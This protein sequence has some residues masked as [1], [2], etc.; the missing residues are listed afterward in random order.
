MNG[1]DSDMGEMVDAYVECA[2]WA[3]TD[4]S[5]CDRYDD[6][7]HGT[8]TEECVEN[9]NPAPL[10]DNYGADDVAPAALESIREDCQ[11]FYDHNA[12]DLAD[13]SPGQAGHDFYLTR[14]G[15]GAGF[16]DRGAGAAGDRLADA[17]RVYGTSELNPFY[18][19]D[20]QLGLSN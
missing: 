8:C 10:A 5:R 12:A 14:N 4:W 11:A 3:G 18:A 7:D 6:D 15:H 2:V 9:G 13:W 19:E 1:T 17:A 16:W 20:G